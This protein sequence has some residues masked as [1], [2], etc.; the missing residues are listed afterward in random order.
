MSVGLVY[1]IYLLA[2]VCFI[3]GL[4][5]LSSPKTAPR[6]NMTGTEKTSTG[7]CPWTCRWNIWPVVQADADQL[8]QS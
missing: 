7:I 2:S 5:Q 4:K 6:G 3:F 8:H 1:L